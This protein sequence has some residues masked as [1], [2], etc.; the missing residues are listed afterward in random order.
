MRFESGSRRSCCSK[1][2]SAAASPLNA[3]SASLLCIVLTHACVEVPMLLASKHFAHPHCPS[4][5]G[6]AS[7]REVVL[8]RT[9]AAG[10]R[11][12]WNWRS[13]W[14]RKQ[15]CARTLLRYPVLY[16]HTPRR[17]PV[18]YAH[19][20]LRYPLVYAHVGSASKLVQAL[21]DL[22]EADVVCARAL[23]C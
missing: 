11:G 16:A 3:A 23:I 7:A 2:Y 14:Q 1:A 9:V 4:A 8:T 12:G 21:P 22:L 6:Y 20:L 13:G 19:A 18:L 10:W 17:Y 5:R 15:I